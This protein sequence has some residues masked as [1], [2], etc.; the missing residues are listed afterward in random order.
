M[1]ANDEINNII[2]QL[3]QLQLQQTEFLSHLET[4]KS[5]EAE[6]EARPDIGVT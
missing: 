6:T 4:A 2:K 1:K 3:K 5:N